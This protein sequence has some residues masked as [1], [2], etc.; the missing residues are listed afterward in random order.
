MCVFLCEREI[1]GMGSFSSMSQPGYIY[2]KV[3]F[4]ST[5]TTKKT[6]EMSENLNSEFLPNRGNMEIFNLSIPIDAYVSFPFCPFLN[7]NLP[8]HI[9]S[10]LLI[11]IRNPT[12]VSA[13]LLFNFAQI[14][15]I[16]VPRSYANLLIDI[17]KFNKI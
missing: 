12:I 8:H 2:F 7:T 9:S 5:T 1:E 3:F 6:Y 14:L 13:L 17:L 10:M 16:K 11:K 4:R 15:A